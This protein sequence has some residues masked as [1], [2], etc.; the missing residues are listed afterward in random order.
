M[1]AQAAAILRN[2]R[3][4]WEFFCNSNVLVSKSIFS[5]LESEKDHDLV[6]EIEF[7]T[8][9]GANHTLANNTVSR[10]CIYFV[11]CFILLCLFG[12]FSQILF[13]H[14]MYKCWIFF[15]FIL[16]CFVIPVHSYSGIEIIPSMPACAQAAIQIRNKKEKEARKNIG[17]SSQIKKI[18]WV[19]ELC[20]LE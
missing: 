16:W 18:R 17:W 15:I 10:E 5:S 3:K 8:H 14:F 2:K 13:F 1:A 19:V 11:Q 6:P 7:I 4:R 9:V 12:E 20:R